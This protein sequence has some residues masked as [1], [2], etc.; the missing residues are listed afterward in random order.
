MMTA[1]FTRAAV[2]EVA[3]FWT[4]LRGWRLNVQADGA[5][6]WTYGDNA[7]LI[8]QAG[9][10]LGLTEQQIRSM[11]GTLDTAQAVRIQQAYPLAFF[12]LHVRHRQVRLLD[13]PSTAF[14]AVKVIP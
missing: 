1:E 2:W 14:P 9:R 4:H 11:V 6:H 12:D 3:E 5:L 8:P 10:M 7:A 13:G